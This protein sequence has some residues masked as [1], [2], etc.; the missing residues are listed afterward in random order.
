MAAKYVA[1]V[2]ALHNFQYTPFEGVTADKFQG[3]VTFNSARQA[4]AA[5]KF[6]M[7]V[8]RKGWVKKEKRQDQIRKQVPVQKAFARPVTLAG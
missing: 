1:G 7:K 2:C 6:E 8:S 3:Y 4:Y 5:G